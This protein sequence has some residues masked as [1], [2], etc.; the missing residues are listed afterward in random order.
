[1]ASPA[2]FS[3]A[4]DSRIALSLLTLLLLLVIRP[5]LLW[6]IAR[7]TNRPLF[8]VMCRLG[9]KPAGLVLLLLAILFDAPQTCAVRLHKRNLV[10]PKKLRFLLTQY[11]SWF[12]LSPRLMKHHLDVLWPGYHVEGVKES[13]NKMVMTGGWLEEASEGATP[14]DER[15]IDSLAATKP[16]PEPKNDP[17]TCIATSIR[18]VGPIHTYGLNHLVRVPSTNWGT[19]NTK[20]RKR[21]LAIEYLNNA[22]YPDLQNIDL[23]GGQTRIQYQPWTAQE[24]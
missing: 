15:F 3:S 17:K 22:A 7:L 24:K 18:N 4:K 16:N 9:G 8:E 10:V 20:K 11:L 19:N 13:H 1:M 2:Y 12:R 23:R 6:R 14:C 21:S 5:L